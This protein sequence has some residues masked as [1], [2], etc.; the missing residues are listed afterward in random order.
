MKTYKH[1][2]KV[3]N[4]GSKCLVVFRTL[5]GES[6]MSLILPTATLPDS[7]HNSIME[8]VETDQA[9]DCFE[10]AEIMFVRYF[11]D[12]RP[13]LRALQVDNRLIKMPTD[14]IIMTPGPQSEI[15]L[16]QLNVLIAEQKNCTIDELINFVK[17]GPTGFDPT[18]N[19]KNVGISTPVPTPA[20]ENVGVLTDQDLAKTYRSQADAMY[21]EAARMRKESDSIDPT[22][23]KP[24]NPT[25]A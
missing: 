23:K 16:S 25:D 19:L 2:G 5:P 20:A 7:Y 4:T 13:M 8:L 15:E 6:N 10:F 12:G 22:K 9:Q 24:I 17:G 18:V 1:I 11:P 14:N 21:K 3:K